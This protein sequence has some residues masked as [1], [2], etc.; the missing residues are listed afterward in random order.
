MAHPHNFRFTIRIVL[1]F[2]KMKRTK[3]LMENHFDGLLEKKKI[4]GGGGG[5]WGK[6]AILGVAD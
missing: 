3:R 2:Y 6:W 5:G 1:K 4:E